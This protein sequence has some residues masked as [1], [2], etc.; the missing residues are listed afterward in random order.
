MSKAVKT[1]DVRELVVDLIM[2][3]EKSLREIARQSGVPCSTISD[4]V[5]YGRV[6]SIENAQYVLAV[7]GKEICIKD[8]ADEEEMGAV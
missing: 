5:N 6:P 1:E 8:I 3:S 2:H 7:F 4:W